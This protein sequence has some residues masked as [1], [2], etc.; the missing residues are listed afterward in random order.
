LLRATSVCDVAAAGIPNDPLR[1]D[2]PQVTR[3]RL[4]SQRWMAHTATT[5]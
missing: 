2:P 3:E 4:T 1:L 5:Q